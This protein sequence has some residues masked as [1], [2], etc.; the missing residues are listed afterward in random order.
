MLHK[1]VSLALT[2][3]AWACKQKRESDQIAREDDGFQGIWHKP[4][5][6]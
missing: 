1:L 3:A 5:R 6:I 2:L 4:M